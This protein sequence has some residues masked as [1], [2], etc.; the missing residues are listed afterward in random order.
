MKNNM[1]IKFG[2][3]GWRAIIAKEFTFD[4]VRIVTQAIADY[5]K[6][7]C[8]PVSAGKALQAK[9]R[10]IVGY[11]CR[12]MSDVYAKIAAEVL[13]ANNIYVLLAKN[14]TPTP[15]VSFA[16][17][18]RSLDAGIV[19]TASH[20]PP[21]FNGIKFKTHLANSADEVTTSAIESFINKNSPK[22]M[23]LDKALASRKAEFFDAG[24]DYIN[25]LKKYI[26]IK[27]IKQHQPKVLVDYM[28]GAG[29]GYF[30]A[31][32][33][34]AANVKA[35][36]NT[37]D[38]LFGGVNPEPIP[39]NLEFSS[40]Y[41]KQADFDLCVALDGD[42]DRIGALRPDGTFITSGQIVS[43]ILLHFLE[44]RK[45]TGSVVKT[46]SG[47]TLIERICQRYN[48]TMFETPVGF[49]YISALMLK[50]NIL[51]GGEESGG[52]GFCGYIPERDGIL[53]SLLLMEML[54][55]R[56][57]SINLVI[58]AMD[59]EYGIF[60]YDRIDMKYPV[61]KA[62]ELTKRLQKNPPR[63]IAG[64]R[65]SRIKTYDGI[66]FILQDSSWLLLRFS[67]TEPLIRIYAESGSQKE[68]QALLNAGKRIIR[69]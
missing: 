48:L 39:K 2:T 28:H 40:K 34:G 4:N 15:A 45:L 57:K 43:L 9:R 62:S 18:S 31:V 6:S 16:I 66:K 21:V 12:F 33:R 65:L 54:A 23:S 10:V 11:D 13:L 52:I 56:K 30:E 25:F 19:I 69:Y 47:T 22:S 58:D 24:L 8:R 53:S 26:D 14:A 64:K 20:N 41:I 27:K 37:I 63:I 67:G 59:K 29:I 61:K 3:D 60:C 50:E 38:P 36:R 42:A 5:I 17:K 44:N 35:I 68:V 1:D 7:S 46:I 55:Y 51:I 32:L 49:K